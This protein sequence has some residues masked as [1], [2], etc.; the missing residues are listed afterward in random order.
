MHE[1][2]KTD[3]TEISNWSIIIL[4][5]NH[6]SREKSGVWGTIRRKHM[7]MNINRFYTKRAA[8]LFMITTHMFR[9]SNVSKK[10]QL[11]SKEVI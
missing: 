2:V 6:D 8:K 5:I 7:G 10:V 11:S 4:P 1:G 9:D 3:M